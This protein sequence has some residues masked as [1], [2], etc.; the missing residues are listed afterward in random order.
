MDAGERLLEVGGGLVGRSGLPCFGFA[1][2]DGGAA[3]SF[4]G[5]VEWVAGLL[6]E[7]IAKEHAERTDVATKRS[8]FE[9]AGGGLEFGEALGPV[10][11]GPE[12]RH[13]V[14]MH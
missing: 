6:A 7:D 11:W 14:I 4:D 9:L 3:E 12:R 5:F 13:E 8:F 2:C 10:G 1:A